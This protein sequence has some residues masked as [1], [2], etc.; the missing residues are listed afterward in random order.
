[1][2][3]LLKTPSEDAFHGVFQPQGD[4]IPGEF[5]FYKWGN[6]TI[7]G[8]LTAADNLGRDYEKSGAKSQ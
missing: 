7:L 3:S 4:E 6:G 1:M 5:R 2:V 8:E